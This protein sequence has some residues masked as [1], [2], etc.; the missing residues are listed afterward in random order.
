VLS[1]EERRLV[2]GILALLLFGAAVRMWRGPVSEQPGTKEAV[3]SL[4]EAVKPP[5]KTYRKN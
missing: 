4:E 2:V 3:P 1:P 5:G